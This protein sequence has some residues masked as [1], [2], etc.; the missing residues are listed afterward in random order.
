MSIFGPLKSVLIFHPW[1]FY[2][3]DSSHE[4]RMDM[5]LFFKQN[6]HNV[7]R[8][9][10]NHDRRRL[11]HACLPSLTMLIGRRRHLT[12]KP[13]ADVVVDLV[14]CMGGVLRE[15]KVTFG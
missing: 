6:I 15:K 9:Q 12:G 13:S 1:G 11:M 5:I 4:N 3:T 14:Q 8:E 7:L 2:G 10:L